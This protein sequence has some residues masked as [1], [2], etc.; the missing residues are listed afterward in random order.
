MALAGLD[1]ATRYEDCPSY[2][3]VARGND[4]SSAFDDSSY[5]AWLA[6]ALFC[7][8]TAVVMEQVLPVTTRGRRGWEIAARAMGATLL[9]LFLSCYVFVRVFFACRH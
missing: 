2:S 9:T 5:D 3:G 4:E 1:P 8:F 6:L 7:W